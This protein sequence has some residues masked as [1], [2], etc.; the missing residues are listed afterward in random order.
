MTTKESECQDREAGIRAQGM[1]M[2]GNEKRER[3]KEKRTCVML[4]KG[5]MI[6]KNRKKNNARDRESESG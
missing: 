1:T 5:E 3:R 2:G 6:G 4:N